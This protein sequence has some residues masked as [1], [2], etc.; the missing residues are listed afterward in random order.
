MS[1]LVLSRTCLLLIYLKINNIDYPK[2]KSVIKYKCQLYSRQF[3]GI[4]VKQ[5]SYILVGN[6]DNK[7]GNKEVIR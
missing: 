6:V 4:R 3:L 2:K 5:E 1:P 7:P